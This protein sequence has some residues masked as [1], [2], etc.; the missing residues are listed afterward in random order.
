ML[1]HSKKEKEKKGTFPIPPPDANLL[2]VDARLVL[3]VS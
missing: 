1:Q 2:S 3:E